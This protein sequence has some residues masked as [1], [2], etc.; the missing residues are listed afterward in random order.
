M[1]SFQV[2][3]FFVL[4]TL[5]N[6]SA[7][8][9]F[10]GQVFY[11]KLDKDFLK[12]L[13]QKIALLK[14]QKI[15]HH[16]E[17]GHIERS[18]VYWNE[19]YGKY[20][21]SKYPLVSIPSQGITY[22]FSKEDVEKFSFEIGRRLS[23]YVACDFERNMSDEEI[24]YYLYVLHMEQIPFDILTSVN[25]WQTLKRFLNGLLYSEDRKNS[26]VIHLKKILEKYDDNIDQG[27]LYIFKTI[28]TDSKLTGKKQKSTCSIL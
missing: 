9:D 25:I 4:F 28:T 11:L 8:A 15:C 6:V 27:V 23:I 3:A 19:N 22:S 17:A 2:L 14:A 20:L 12:F 26:S 7:F 10:T 18:F 16:Y 21:L 24:A 13:E 5:L 1:K